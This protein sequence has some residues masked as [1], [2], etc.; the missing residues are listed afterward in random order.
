MPEKIHE[1]F[2][3][4]I[5]RNQNFVNHFKIASGDKVE[6]IDP[7]VLNEDLGGP[8]FRNARI[9]IGNITYCGD[10]E[11]DSFHS[12][13]KNHGHIFNKKY[14]KVIL[15]VILKNDSNYF[16][17]LNEEKRKIPTVIITDLLDES[18]KNEIKT[19]INSE[20]NKSYYNLPCFELNT[21]LDPKEK[22]SYL[23][24]LGIERFRKR[25]HLIFERLKEIT[26]LNELKMKEPLIRY[27]LGE[28]FYN[29]KFSSEDFADPLVWQQ[30]L[31][32]FV[33]EALG[34]THNKEIMKKLAKLCDINFLNTFSDKPNY[35]QYIESALFNV[36]GMIPDVKN[37][38]DEETSGYTKTLAE[39]WSEMKSSYTSLFI[40]QAQWNF[41][42]LRPQNFPTI[43][44][45]AGSRILYKIIKLNF[46][47]KIISFIETNED[48]KKI[49]AFL[50]SEFKIRSDGYW[51]N[52]YVFDN[53]ARTTINYFVGSS[54]AID[55]I[56]N[57]VLPVLYIYYD[58]FG[59]LHSVKKVQKCYI[60]FKQENDSML[61]SEVLRKLNIE[62]DINNK[63]IFHQGM[64][65]LYKSYCSRNKC[66][67]CKI[68]AAVFN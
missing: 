51:R 64:L 38:P 8:D 49:G 55:I 33:F 6:I 30:L 10:I 57:S 58:V 2:L 53:P 52:H 26:Y 18:L 39:N 20:K 31:Y 47:K 50:L 68:G 67:E 23:Y 42:R 12:D 54:R 61:V 35:L 40:N 9:K 59:K 28:E 65:E 56:I 22:V 11:I 41:F 48:P 15:H 29:R 63:S 37:L 62:D 13:W 21:A 43:R 66:L 17:V 5:W 45:A 1:K 60:G 3:H 44:I 25:S 27:E 46:I 19:A 32:E 36:S 34:Y 7:G 16:Y 14:N 24:R 4:E